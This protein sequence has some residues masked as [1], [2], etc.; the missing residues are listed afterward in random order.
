MERVEQPEPHLLVRP[1]PTDLR[2]QPEPLPL[3]D[4]RH[5]RRKLELVRGAW[6][7]PAVE[8]CLAVAVQEVRRL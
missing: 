1:P 3:R 5:L 7:D 4:V 8:P 6:Q 2:W